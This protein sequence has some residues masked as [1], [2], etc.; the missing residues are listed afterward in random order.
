MLQW[1]VKSRVTDHVSALTLQG[2]SGSHCVGLSWA[3]QKTKARKQW[4]LRAH[5][6]RSRLVLIE[7][8]RSGPR[9]A[10]GGS[11]RRNQDSTLQFTSC[12]STMFSSK[13]RPT[14][15]F[16]GLSPQRQASLRIS[17]SR[18]TSKSINPT[19]RI[20]IDQINDESIEATPHVMPACIKWLQ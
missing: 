14:P 17:A 7:A 2:P 10:P 9:R 19:V 16:H 5:C 1:Y 6:L 11:V 4:A 8:P 3:L 15:C 12:A 18:C 13:V 20:S